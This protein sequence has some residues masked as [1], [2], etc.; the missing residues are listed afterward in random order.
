MTEIITKKF[1][2]GT[3]AVLKNEKYGTNWPVVYI[4]NNNEEAYV[5]ETTDI[6]IRS[7]QHWA[8]DIRRN[9]DK[10][11]VIGDETFNKSA[12]LD[13]ESFLIKYMAADKKYKL[14]NGNGGLQN[15]NY[16]QREMYETKFREIWLQLKS[17]GLV[18]N[19]LKMIAN[20][21][22]FKYSPYKSL[23][24]DQYMIVNDILS[25]LAKLV[26]KNEKGT[27]IV[28]GGA[29]TGK[30][31]LGIYILK[32][33]SQ[34]KDASQIEI[35]EDQ[36][37]QNLSEILK[38]NDAV[39]DL[40]IGLVI[41]MENLRSTLKKV[42]KS[43]KGL[44]SKMV[45]SPHEVGKSD[46]TYDLLIVDEAHRLRRRKNLTAYG[47]FDENNR[48]FNLGKDGNELD[49]ILLKSKYQIFFYDEDQS[50]KPTDVR[51]ECFEKLMLRK[52]Y[53]SYRLEA[54]LRCIK[55]GN[56]YIDYIKAI[57]SNNPPKKKI[58]FKEY[59]LKL[60][61]DANKMIE[62]IKSKDNEYG[63]C[64]NIAG[65][66]WKWNSKGK[67]LPLDSTISRDYTGA[68]D[69]EIDGHKYIWNTQ[70]YDWINSTNSVNEIGSIH[71]TQG[72]DLNYA[73]LII[74]NE[75]K[76]DL[77]K[78]EFIVDRN[79][80]YDAKGKSSATDEELLGYLLNIYRTMML[81]GMLGTYV[82]VCDPNLRE[83]LK[84]YF[85]TKN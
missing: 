67:H 48:K 2:A 31:V 6:S 34:A 76:Y 3:P 83:Y 56:E 25:D 65:Y 80:Y 61:D 9:L 73:G 85:D 8:N 52:N 57:F 7:N 44:N 32:L 45:L 17:K 24:T 12:I 39:D 28:E 77:E 5:G 30:T 49:W 13:L 75:L 62:D 26:Y 35:E 36:V 43:I 14:Q 42:F 16:Y 19:D 81:R 40:K 27:F 21:D 4:L 71:T 37:E 46:E 58:S 1:N 66:A 10:I 51:K 74:G 38:I 84:K 78:N 72:F 15:H 33:L 82:Y 79:N 29:G 55:G 23:T 63:L 53:H 41:P 20:S 11:N 54:Q 47:P 50:I 69:I 64:R 68:Y 60:F 70:A 18:K 22:L 59:D